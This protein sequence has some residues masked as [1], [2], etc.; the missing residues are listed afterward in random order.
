MFSLVRVVVKIW[1]LW[2]VFAAM[3][4][5]TSGSWSRRRRQRWRRSFRR[6]VGGTAQ[7]LI[8]LHPNSTAGWYDYEEPVGQW[9]I[10]PNC[11]KVHHETEG[12][13]DYVAINISSEFQA[14]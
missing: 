7:S 4:A 2:T 3:A 12:G 10:T 6:T 5:A 1:V 9:D 14:L 11:T 13:C 8:S